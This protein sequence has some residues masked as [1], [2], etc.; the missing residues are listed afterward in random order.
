MPVK[1]TSL[2]KMHQITGFNSLSSKHA[3][4]QRELERL[5]MEVEDYLPVMKDP[6]SITYVT[7]RLQERLDA[8]YRASKV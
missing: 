6:E 1:K 5:A 8:V 4:Y 7:A 2:R 3:S